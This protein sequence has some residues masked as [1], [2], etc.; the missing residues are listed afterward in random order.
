[1]CTQLTA[2]GDNAKTVN[3]AG[4]FISKQARNQ[5]QI[6]LSALGEAIWDAVND[7]DNEYCQRLRAVLNS[8]LITEIRPK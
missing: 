3:E 4:S 8:K 1:M 5:D 7:E 6:V 2:T